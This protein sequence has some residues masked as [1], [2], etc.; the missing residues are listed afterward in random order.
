[1]T[2][3]NIFFLAL[4]GLL[5]WFCHHDLKIILS[6]YSDS[7]IKMQTYEVMSPGGDE[8]DG[9]RRDAVG[10]EWRMESH[11]QTIEMRGTVNECGHGK[12][13]VY[14]HLHLLEMEEVNEE[15]DERQRRRSDDHY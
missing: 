8:E 6:S 7:D 13:T 1:L 11:P 12:D 9:G 15:E 2:Y 3:L 10:T 4:C 5:L 14:N